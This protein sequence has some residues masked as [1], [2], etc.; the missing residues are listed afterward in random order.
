MHY[1]K[2]VALINTEPLPADAEI[3]LDELINA[4]RDDFQR[5]M[6]SSLSEALF[7]TRYCGGEQA[8]N[9]RGRT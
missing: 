1:D 3:Q 5:M 7:E 2:A 6:I 9:E 4:E 8:A